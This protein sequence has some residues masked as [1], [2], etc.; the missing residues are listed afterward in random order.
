MSAI[1]LKADNLYDSVSLYGSNVPD[2][3]VPIHS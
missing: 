1:E 2:G 3:I